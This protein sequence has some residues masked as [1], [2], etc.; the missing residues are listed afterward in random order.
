MLPPPGSGLE[1]PQP[2]SLGREAQVLAEVPRLLLRLPRL[3]REPRAAGQPVL[4]V[5]G[6]GA[7]DASL[8]ALRRYL[9]GLGYRVSGWGLGRNGGNVPELIPRVLARTARLAASARAPV[10]LVGWSLGGNLSREVARE[11]PDLVRQVIT[12]GTPV[13]GG[14]RY[15]VAAG[16]YRRQGYDLSEIE[17]YVR[18]RNEVPID[19]P[20]TAI[21]SRRDA[22]VAWGACIDRSSPDVE[23]IEVDTSHLGLTLSPEVYRLV[24]RRLAAGLDGGGSLPRRQVG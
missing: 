18:E 6:F 3:R 15:T 17:R 19:V 5:P 4:A 14:P 9:R 10:S 20:I 21:Y 12:L 11:R 22:I 8:W 23:H 7:N 13:I 24:A 16:A 1:P 2:S